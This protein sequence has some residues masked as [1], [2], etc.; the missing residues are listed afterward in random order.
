LIMLLCGIILLGIA[1]ICFHV[2]IVS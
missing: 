1:V 2:G